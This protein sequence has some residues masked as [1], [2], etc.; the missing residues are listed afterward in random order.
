M[1]YHDVQQNTEEWFALKRGKFTAS[2]FKSLFAAKSTDTY[3]KAIYK[4]AYERL[5]GESPESFS[6]KWT[7]HGH[8]HEPMARDAYEVETFNIVEDAGFIELNE[9]VGCSPDGLVGSDGLVEFKCPAYN[10]HFDYINADKL[11]TE[12]FYQVHGQIFVSGRKWCDFESFLNPFKPFIIRVERD[13]EVCKKIEAA[14]NEAIE[15][16]KKVIEK[17]TKYQT[18]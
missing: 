7:D 10:T 4:V 11:P 5:T 2:A 15:K 16:A 3:K 1:I 14:L 12:Y 6:N 18:R 13:E 9:W 17:L 8:E